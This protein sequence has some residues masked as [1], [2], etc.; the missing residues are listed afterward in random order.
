[1]VLDKTMNFSAATVTVVRIGST[2]GAAN[3]L[4][5]RNLTQTAGLVMR[6]DALGVGYI[7]QYLKKNLFICHITK[8][9]FIK[10]RNR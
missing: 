3:D 10:I 4:F 6:A 5:Q 7:N 8:F 1:M 2:V 9:I